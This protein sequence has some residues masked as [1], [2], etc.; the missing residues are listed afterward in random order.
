MARPKRGTTTKLPK[1]AQRKVE[2]AIIEGRPV[3]G[4]L[5]AEELKANGFSVSGSTVWR[6]AVRFREKVQATK[7][8]VDRAKIIT[9]AVD[10][11][12]GALSEAVV[13]MVQTELF[14][15]LVA[16]EAASYEDDPEKR[17]K[18]LSMAA[19][20]ISDLT[21]ASTA[22]RKYQEEVRA[23]IS[24]AISSAEQIAMN[25]GMTV[26]VWG[27]IRREFLGIQGP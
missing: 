16:I 14:D 10:G 8:A 15:V 4:D 20:T 2:E 25:R 26:E 17:L 22:L 1:E 7:D 12:P 11:A 24:T 18:I 13:A 21:R 23:S 27:E 19:N 3:N 5:I 9:A 6:H